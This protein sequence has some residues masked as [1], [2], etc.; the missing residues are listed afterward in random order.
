M[1]LPNCYR[2]DCSVCSCADG[3]A[4]YHADCLAVLA[5]L[6]EESVH[7][8]VTSPPYWGL[9]DYG[10]DGQ[11]GLEKT[12]EEFV[13]KMV[14]VFRAVRRVLRSDGTCWVN[15]GDSYAGGGRGGIG[16]ASTLE[17]GHRNQNESR[18]DQ[19]SFGRSGDGLKPKDL[20]M[21]PAR[22]ALAL[23]ADGWWLRSDIIWS[24]PNP[25]PESVT[26]RPTKAHE[27]LFLLAKSARYFYDADAVREAY[28]P[29]SYERNKYPKAKST[30][31]GRHTPGNKDERYKES[32]IQPLNPSGRNKKSVWTISTQS[33]P[34]AHFATF[35]TALVEPCILA[36]TSEKGVC[37]ECGAPW[38]RVVEKN[39]QPTRPGQQSKVK[40]VYQKI[41][42]K[43][44]DA[45][46][47]TTSTIGGIVGNRD[48]ERHCTVTN[49]IGW[50]PGCEC[51]GN[52]SFSR[53][54]PYVPIPATVLD[55][56]AGSATTLQV[57]RWLGRHA[58]GIELSEDYC[59]LAVKRIN[60]PREKPSTTKPLSDQMVMF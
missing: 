34:A 57:A 53:F 43:M 51:R 13:A 26:D 8:C 41:H 46:K 47:L 24:K 7:C 1:S 35:P 52:T 23:Q 56:F 59:E 27:Y 16:G 55:P 22:V 45:S 6:P 60:Q 20:C 42:G 15:L 33:F 18:K 25:M 44:V 37:P 29:Q 21:M 14:D 19:V 4:L 48:P 49:T 32:H 30:S 38:R 17:G 12:L 5:Q 11:F 54:S 2:C 39:R 50:E 36:G 10:V 3:I 58:I 31:P 9:R 40:D 28:D